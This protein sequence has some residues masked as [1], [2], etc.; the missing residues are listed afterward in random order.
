MPVCT[1]YICVSL[2]LSAKQDIGIE[3]E[4]FPTFLFAL[5]NLPGNIASFML[6][7]KI[8]RKKLL[9]YSMLLAAASG[10]LFAFT[11]QNTV[12]LA[13]IAACAFNAFS[14][15]GW[16]SLDALSTESFPTN[17]RTTGMGLLSAT[18]RL[19]SIVAM[20]VNAQLEKSVFLLFTVTSVNMVIGA[21]VSFWLPRETAGMSLEG[22]LYT[23]AARNDEEFV[24]IHADD[25]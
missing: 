3:N 6:I 12:W 9:A 25:D 7:E 23:A 11:Q 10:F 24:V 17:Y 19:S 20:F 15:S 4:F 5:A 1:T 22:K 13:V 14:V 18:G 2:G 21:L 16:N 8:G